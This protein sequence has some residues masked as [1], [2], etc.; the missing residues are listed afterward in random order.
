MKY[1]RLYGTYF[2]YNF[3][4]LYIYKFDFFIGNISFVLS[5]LALLATIFI[6]FNIT[7]SIG[8]FNQEEI[9]FLYAFVS[10]ARALWNFFLINTINIGSYIKSGKLDLL[11]IRPVNPLFQL[12]NERMD[13]ES[14]GEIIY[15]II[16]LVITISFLDVSVNLIFL[17][18]FILFTI[19]SVL[20]YG[21]I[22]LAANSLSFWLVDVSSL[23]YIL[24]RFDELTRY[25][26]NIYSKLIRILMIIIPFAFIGFY[27]TVLLL[28]LNSNFTLM[29]IS[30]LIGPFTFI[31]V[32]IFVWKFGLL[33]YT[34]TGS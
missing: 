13:F 7:D 24:W 23:N 28:G 29:V 18:K 30:I 20:C 16:L 5:S 15:S 25:P 19:S 8:G 10:L 27:P 21:A 31:L 17:I 22:H 3:K 14:I 1:L 6:I 12:V 32:Y 4:S 33:K 34:S 11:L 2:K 9:V 26:I